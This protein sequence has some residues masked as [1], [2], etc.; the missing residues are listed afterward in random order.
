MIELY[1]ILYN[2]YKYWRD[3]QGLAE[4]CGISGVLIPGIS[5]NSDPTANVLQIWVENCKSEATVDK[6]LTYLEQLDREDIIDDVLPL[7]GLYIYH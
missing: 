5:T 6:L 2:E 3:W 1:Y 7:I 4:L